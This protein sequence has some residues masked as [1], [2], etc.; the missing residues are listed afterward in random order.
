MA[1]I[2]TVGVLFAIGI[3]GGALACGDKL[4][5][6]PP[7]PARDTT[8]YSVAVIPLSGTVKVGEHLQHAAQVQCR[9]SCW[10]GPP[11]TWRRQTASTN[12]TT[13]S[14]CP[15]LENMSAT[16]RVPIGMRGAAPHAHGRQLAAGYSDPTTDAF[17]PPRNTTGSVDLPRHVRRTASGR[18][19]AAAQ[20]VEV[21]VNPLAQGLRLW[22][23]IDR[24]TKRMDHPSP[25]TVVD[26]APLPSR[27]IRFIQASRLPKVRGSRALL[28]MPNRDL[29]MFGVS[30]GEP[31]DCPAGCAYSSAIGLYYKGSVGWVFVEDMDERDRGEMRSRLDS[32]PSSALD[33]QILT[34]GF[35]DT[36]YHTAGGREADLIRDL[37]IRHPALP[38][39]VL[40][41][42]VERLYEAPDEGLRKLIARLPSVR[43]DVD[44]LTLLAYLPYD[45]GKEAA[46]KRLTALI[47]RL[48]H[49]SSTPARTMFIVARAIQISEDTTL[50][51]RVAEHPSVRDNTGDPRGAFGQPSRAAPPD[52]REPSRLAARARRPRGISRDGRTGGDHRSRQASARRSGGGHEQGRA[53]RARERGIESGNPMGRIAPTARRGASWARLYVQAHSLAG[54]SAGGRDRPR[55]LGVWPISELG[56]DHAY[57]ICSDRLRSC[58][59]RRA[60]RHDLSGQHS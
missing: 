13:C 50:V 29:V 46:I 44:L 27:V 43:D 53:A 4:P 7:V 56:W 22:F 52:D 6:I 45:G 32:F 24:V 40:A 38:R 14:W 41:D 59:L 1:R 17:L 15:W 20:T 36:L 48:V 39:S 10:R 55:A 21:I 12:R 9:G 33:R 60:E 57:T 47:P 5:L 19:L 28:R 51:R 3:S 37:V 26:T 54:H 35:L 23:D 11:D 30:Y 16:L 2:G 34:Q 25:H 42:Q 58:L 8:V 18:T 31:H 49:D